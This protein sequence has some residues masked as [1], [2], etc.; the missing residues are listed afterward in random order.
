MNIHGGGYAVDVIDFSVNINPTMTKQ[1]MDKLLL[2]SSESALIYPDIDNRKLVSLIGKYYGIEKDALYV[3][4]GATD[5]LY[6]LAALRVFN[7]VGIIEP[8]FSE[9]RRSFELYGTEVKSIEFNKNESSLLKA[10]MACDVELIVLCMPNSPTGYAYSAEFMSQLLNH[11]HN[12][13]KKLLIDESF[14]LFED[15]PSV[16]RHGISDVLI[17]MS[18]TKYYG[19]PGLRIGYLAGDKG[20][21][22]EL[23]KFQQPWA[24]NGLLTG[25]MAELLENKTFD[26]DTKYWYHREKN[27]MVEELAQ[28]TYLSYIEGASN[29]LFFKMNQCTGTDLNQWLLGNDPPMAIRCCEDYT[30]LGDNYIRIGLKDSVSNDRLIEALRK[31][32]G[33]RI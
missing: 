19:I 14:R 18:L 2:K 6:N 31:Y 8:T 24:L 1:H 29:F 3:G 4:N 11:I 20:L 27:K 28:L 30:G 13:S 17:L 16:Y 7:S 21:I 33:E 10:V 22:A 9:Y 26:A 25:I 23:Q 12:S 5:C 15:I 32:E